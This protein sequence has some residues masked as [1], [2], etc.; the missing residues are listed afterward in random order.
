MLFDFLSKVHK[1]PPPELKYIIKISFEN[2]ATEELEKVEEII[3]WISN[4]KNIKWTY[5]VEK[6]DE[7]CKN[8]FF[9]FNDQNIAMQFKLTWG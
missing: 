4:Y 2:S 9:C 1:K 7:N 5:Y 6:T 8:M 3:N